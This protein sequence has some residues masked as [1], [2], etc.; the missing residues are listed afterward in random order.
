MRGCLAR[1]V[2]DSLARARAMAELT[3]TLAWTLSDLADRVAETEDKLAATFEILAERAEPSRA[4]AL[5]AK[6]TRAMNFAARERSERERWAAAARQAEPDA[7]TEA[8]QS[9]HIPK[10]PSR[11]WPD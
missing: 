9:R 4:E 11:G 7:V 8:E 10:P 6:A 1:R 3:R 2:D 5:R